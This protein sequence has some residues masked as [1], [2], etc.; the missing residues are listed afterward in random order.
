MK[1]RDKEKNSNR[2]S[3]R[4]RELVKV[5]DKEINSDRGRERDRE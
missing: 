1:G 2:G 3:E 4:D 5:R